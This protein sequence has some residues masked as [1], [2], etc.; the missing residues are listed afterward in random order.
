M[1][2]GPSRCG[3][4]GDAVHGVQKVSDLRSDTAGL[5]VRAAGC[6]AVSVWSSWRCGRRVQMVSDLR[7]DTA[8]LEVRV[9]AVGFGDRSKPKPADIT[10]P[11][12]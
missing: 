9:R 5:E 1:G 4:G 10:R 3:V 11:A 8:G 12:L 7:S 6:G 2:C